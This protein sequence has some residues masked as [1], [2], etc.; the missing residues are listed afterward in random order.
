MLWF[1]LVRLTS[2]ISVK[3]NEHSN[4]VQSMRQYTSSLNFLSLNTPD[5]IGNFSEEFDSYQKDGRLGC[6]S[7]VKDQRPS[8][9]K[10]SSVHC[11]TTSV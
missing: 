5:E 10:G 7:L 6:T 3:L 8:K 1:C 4:F 2:L 11:P 9:T